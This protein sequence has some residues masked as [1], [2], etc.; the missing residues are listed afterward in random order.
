MFVVSE[1]KDLAIPKSISFKC[2]F[3]KTCQGVRIEA[4]Q[5]D[6]KQ[7]RMQSK[8]ND[9]TSSYNRNIFKSITYEVG[10]FQVTCYES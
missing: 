5:I 10:W 3:T 1:E 9:L 6:I 7:L 4:G 8:F 2:P